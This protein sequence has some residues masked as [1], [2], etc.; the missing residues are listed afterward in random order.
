MRAWGMIAHGV[1]LLQ[2][3]F[4]EDLHRRLR[5]PPTTFGKPRVQIGEGFIACTCLLLTP[6][7]SVL[8][9]PPVFSSYIRST[10]CSIWA[11][12]SAT[13]HGVRKSIYKPWSCRAFP[14]LCQP[15]PISFTSRLIDGTVIY[16]ENNSLV[17]TN[18]RLSNLLGPI[19]CLMSV[20]LLV[21]N[22]SEREAGPEASSLAYIRH[23]DQLHLP[24]RSM[25]NP[26]CP[27]VAGGF[28]G[29]GSLPPAQVLLGNCFASGVLS[30]VS[31]CKL[32]SM[33]RGMQL[34]QTAK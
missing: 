34:V 26:D 7:K 19:P 17:D 12:R 33:R 20:C 27:C 13:S 2:C 22:R 31:V 6:S 10:Q 32:D 21:T 24:L 9:I 18:E 1:S 3:S 29:S 28:P 16:P 5:L 30:G 25:D 15:T 14:L 11:S 4:E 23:C 8:F